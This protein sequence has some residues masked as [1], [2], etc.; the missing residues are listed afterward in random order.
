MRKRNTLLAILLLTYYLI[1][2][3]DLK[4]ITQVTTIDNFTAGEL[5]YALFV[6]GSIPPSP[7]VQ[8]GAFST[9]PDGFTSTSLL[10]GEREFLFTILGGDASST[11]TTTILAGDFSVEVPI[12]GFGS[13]IVQYDGEDG[14]S[15]DMNYSGLVGLEA[16]GVGY[17]LTH[18]GEAVGLE[19]V[20]QHADIQL[21]VIFTVVSPTH[22]TCIGAATVLVS[23]T[24]TSY[25]VPFSEFIGSCDFSDVGAI[26]MDI[27]LY[28]NNNFT[29]QLLATYSEAEP[30]PGDN[31]N[32]RP[33]MC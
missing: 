8:K 15:I 3:V 23:T 20:V 14:G 25:Y 19:L 16:A 1:T 2:I 30:P 9:S 10:G 13:L 6:L 32:T 26:Q 31:M 22:A 18:G 28:S 17:D 11:F 33:S 21:T 27:P 29:F 7:A 24:N 12:G 5:N 4:L